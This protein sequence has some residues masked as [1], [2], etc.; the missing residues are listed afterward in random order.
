MMK[1]L[2][3]LG[4]IGLACGCG[5]CIAAIGNKV[6]F[7]DQVAARRPVVIDGRIYVVDV[8]TGKVMALEPAAAQNAGAF[9]V[10]EHRSG[11]DDD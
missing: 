5:G 9:E 4:V 11:I 8:C 7:P 1:K 10:I 2:L 3:F 6:D